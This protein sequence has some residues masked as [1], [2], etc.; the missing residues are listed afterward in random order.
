M[1]EKMMC[2]TYSEY[3]EMK[4]KIRE[5]KNALDFYIEWNPEPLQEKVQH[6]VHVELFNAYCVLNNKTKQF[7]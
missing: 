4:R 6:D 7:K 5:S 2:I 1:Q 3:L